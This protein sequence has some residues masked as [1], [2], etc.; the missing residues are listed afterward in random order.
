MYPATDCLQL[1]TDCGGGAS[2]PD[3]DGHWKDLLQKQVNKLVHRR[4]NKS[5]TCNLTYVGIQQHHIDDFA[6]SRSNAPPLKYDWRTITYTDGSVTHAGKSGGPG[7]GAAVFTPATQ[8]AVPLSIASAPDKT[9]NVAELAAIHKAVQMGSD[10]IATDSLCSIYQI[11]RQMT[12]PQ[13][14]KYH[15]HGHILQ[16]IVATIAKR[17]KPLTIIKVKSHSGVVGNETADHIAKRV[18]QGKEEEACEYTSPP[19]T[20]ETMYWPVKVEERKQPRQGRLRRGN[21]QHV[22]ASE[23]KR[24]YL[25]NIMQAVLTEAKAAVKM[26]FSNTCTMYYQFWQNMVQHFDSAT[27]HMVRTSKLT[28]GQRAVALKYRTGTVYT[29]KQRWRFGFADSDRCVL[30]GEP[31]GGH[32]M[33]AACP[34]L[35]KMYAHR[36]HMVGKRILKAVIDGDR[37]N[38]VVMLD[39]G[40]TH[41]DEEM[42]DMPHRIPHQALPASM[43]SVAKQAATQCSIPD[44]FM[45]RPA[46]SK[47]KA[48]YT[49]IEFKFCRDT[50]P[51]SQSA[52]AQ[53]QHSQ[54]VQALRDADKEAIVDVEV[55]LVGVSGAIFGEHTRDPLARLGVTPAT[56]N[57][58]KYTLNV[59]AVQ[60]L[61]WIYVSKLGREQALK[62]GVH[63]RRSMAKAY[64]KK[65]S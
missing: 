52:R 10:V 13:D 20:R 15:Q 57:K 47:D 24:T 23:K 28:M 25:P 43:S 55:V 64:N 18:A 53:L 27:Y 26:G 14:H 2:T 46:T 51:N 1:P 11:R 33:A 59:M 22:A 34:N 12:R 41:Q 37:G 32:H 6:Q 60:Q 29:A 49:I 58:L 21:G 5:R 36:H 31:D 8:T 65:G 54:L 9:I 56:W 40:C 3:N 38:E 48:R 7:I 50:D 4:A 19:S 62:P 30:C 45:Y 39:V 61:H 42:P 63:G 44:G 35:L 17:Q 16:E